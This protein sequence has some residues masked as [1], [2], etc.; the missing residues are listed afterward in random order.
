MDDEKFIA[1]CDDKGF[2]IAEQLCREAYEQG[3]LD[4]MEVIKDKIKESVND[5]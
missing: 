4:A 1:W 5:C 2:Y 3:W